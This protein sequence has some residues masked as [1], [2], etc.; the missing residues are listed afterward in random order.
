MS[1]PV[2]S[3][4]I[5]ADRSTRLKSSL[6]NTLPTRQRSGYARP[7]SSGDLLKVK[8]K[9]KAGRIMHAAGL[10]EPDSRSWV[11]TAHHARGEAGGRGPLKGKFPDRQTPSSSPDQQY[12]S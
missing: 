10:L 7:T 4:R 2:D 8:V 6:E 11:G 12:Q 1:T 9:V 5:R 3:R